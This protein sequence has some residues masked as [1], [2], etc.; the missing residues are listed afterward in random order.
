MCEALIAV[1]GV[2]KE[3]GI[4]RLCTGMGRSGLQARRM[5]DGQNAGDEMLYAEEWIV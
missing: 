3:R 5:Y 1:T 2:M 4:D